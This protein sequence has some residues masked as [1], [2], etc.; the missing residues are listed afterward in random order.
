MN[1]NRLARIDLNLLV[2]LHIL[3]EEGSVSRAADRLSIT[4]PAMS[5]TLGRLRETFDD[6]LFVRSKRGIQPTPRALGLAGELKSLLAQV[7][8]LLDA[9]EFTPAGYRC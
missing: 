4:Q 7:D 3:L 2:A 1:L 9:G 5:K 8:G 6:P